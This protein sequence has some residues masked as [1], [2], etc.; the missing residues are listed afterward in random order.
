MI[1]RVL[2]RIR[3]VQILFSCSQGETTDLRKA[4]NEL[5]FSLQKSYDL[6]FYL[7]SLLVELTDTYAQKVDARKAKLLPSEEDIRPNIKLLNNKFISQLRRN[8]QLEKYLSERPFS[9][10][11][12]EAFLKKVLD[13]ILN[14]DVYKDYAAND[15]QDYNDDREFW[16]KIFKH[17]ICTEEDLYTILEDESLYWN[18]DIEIIESFV[19]KTIKRF[20]EE[21]GAEQDL[22]PMFKDDTDREFAVKLLRESLFDGKEYRQLI[23]KYTQNW[24][25]ERIA[26]MDMVIMQIAIAEIVTF[27]SI[28]ISVTLNEYID[29]AKSYS[30][31]KSASFINGILDAI[32]KELKEE[33]KIIKK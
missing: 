4:E 9:W 13:N 27:P 25:S 2:I 20:E 16:R 11:D 28:P 8:K 6:Y 19:L 1:N 24:E 7:L 18:D 3:V 12:H 23:D 14:S 26:L 15:L 22:L 17:I 31:A 10:Y 29:I 21:K 5:L 32:V 30:T 33:K